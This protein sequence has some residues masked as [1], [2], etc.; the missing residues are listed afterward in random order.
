M[1]SRSDIMGPRAGVSLFET[2]VSLA[3][4]SL[5]VAVAATAIRPPSPRLLAEAEISQLVRAAQETRLRAIQEGRPV[6][7]ETDATCDDTP[8]PIFFP[9][10]SARD[11][12]L[13]VGERQINILPLTGT[14]DT[15]AFRS[16]T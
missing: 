6:R 14:L 2:M 7:M 15:A 10:G 8:A 12:P 1:I 9:D 13:C 4:L 16:D 3:I 5:I 11:G